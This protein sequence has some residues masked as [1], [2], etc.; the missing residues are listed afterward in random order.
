M[1]ARL[2]SPPNLKLLFELEPAHRVFFRNLA[3]T[4]LRRSVPPVVTKTRPGHFWNDV[5]VHSG[6][7]WGAFIESMLWHLAV[8]SVLWTVAQTWVKHVEIQQRKAAHEALTYYPPPKTFPA[9]GGRP[10]RI[11]ERHTPQR[12]TSKSALR[13]T[14][15]RTPREMKPPELKTGQSER[16]SVMAALPSS[17]IP[18]FAP[19]LREFT[20]R[21]GPA[22]AVAPAANIK[23]ATTRRLNL[24][25]DSAVAPAANVGSV[26]T[27]RAM[28][29]PSAA[30]VPPAP[31]LQASTAKRS[32]TQ[33]GNPQVVAP[34][35]QL[36]VRGVSSRGLASL[37]RPDVVMPSASA[38][39]SGIPGNGRLNSRL[40]LPVV[41]PAP[42]GQGVGTFSRNKPGLSI[43]GSSAI[44]PAPSIKAA[45]GLSGAGR[46]RSLAGRDIAVV[47]PPPSIGSGNATGGP[48]VASLP[49]AGRSVIPP[50]A[51]LGGPNSVAGGNGITLS[52]GDRRAI[53]PTPSI[54]GA[55]SSVGSGRVASLS[56]GQQALPP[57][58]SLQDSLSSI[59][60]GAA[61]G[62]DVQATPTAPKIDSANVPATIELPIRVIGMAVSLPN[63]SYFSNYEVFIAERRVKKGD[64]ELIKLVYESLPYQPRLADYGLDNSKVYKLRVTRDP[65]CDETLLQ[66][67]WPQTDEKHSG[68]KYATGPPTLAPNDRNDLLPCYRTTAD[69]YR[70]AVTQDR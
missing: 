53:A 43:S 37:P 9:L 7:P 4:L 10:P 1:D 31:N 42:S 40:D 34:T 59:E 11:Q 57:S 41:P 5:F 63:S 64:P 49:G 27:R 52:V 28:A 48:R 54:G 22:N 2:K 12:P 3:D 35:P 25:Q 47:P 17:A 16:Q 56:G 58:S 30:V 13:V 51:S 21:A 29:T 50:P 38:H 18:L 55:G 20:V 66:M 61:A 6:L 8:V 45:T 26:S 60:N 36:D 44:S 24:P 70:R 69:D 39:A 15:E 33:I 14:R 23:Q 46:S 32:G 62:S 67:T 65:A 19:K 68:S